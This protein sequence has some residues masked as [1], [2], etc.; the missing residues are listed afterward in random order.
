MTVQEAIDFVDEIKP[1]AFSDKIKLRWINQIEGRIALELLLKTREEAEEDYQYSLEELETDLLIGSPHDDVYTWWL[2]AQID[3]ANGEYDKAAN[4]MA[5]FN[6]AWSGLARWFL[7]AYDP[8]MN[9]TPSLQ[10]ENGG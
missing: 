6:A 2:Q 1:N 4:T 8:D 5:V 7:Q 3:L 10:S 9:G